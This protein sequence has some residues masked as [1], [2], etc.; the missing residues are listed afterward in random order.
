M[1]FS[2]RFSYKLSESDANTVDTMPSRIRVGFVG[3][4]ATGWAAA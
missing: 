1:G 2:Y 3:L 4:S